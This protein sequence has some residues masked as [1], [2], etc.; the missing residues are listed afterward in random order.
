M[1]VALQKNTCV[2]KVRVGEDAERYLQTSYRALSTEN[3]F[4]T[5]PTATRVVAPAR[6]F[7]GPV[8][9]GRTEEDCLL[10]SRFRTAEKRGEV[11]MKPRTS[12]RLEKYSAIPGT[13][14]RNRGFRNPHTHT[15]GQEVK[16]EVK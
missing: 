14:L 5:N 2:I 9:T 7:P 8:S 6:R 16:K 3:G 12:L 13:L 15:T 11:A 10:G 4:N 1:K